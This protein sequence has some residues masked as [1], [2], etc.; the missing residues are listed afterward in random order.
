[1]EVN[2]GNE[3]TI[4]GED[5]RVFASSEWAERGFC[6]NCGTHLFYRI[7]STLEHMIPVG[8]FDDDPRFSFDTEVFINA[9]PD[10]YEFANNTEKFT[11]DQIFAQFGPTE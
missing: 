7:K 6:G 3:V 1:M 4:S 5:L 10:Y 9:K 11:G 8:L 2:C